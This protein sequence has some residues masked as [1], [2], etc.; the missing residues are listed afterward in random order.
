[1][2]SPNL[3]LS[4]TKEQLSKLPTLTYS[5]RVVEINTVEQAFSAINVLRSNLIVG[6]DTET[7]PSFRKGRT[8]NVSLLQIATDDCCYL[9][10]LNQIGFIPEMKTLFEDESITKV[11][12]SLRDDFKQLHKIGDFEPKSVIELQSFVRDY[13]IADSS[14]QK[15]YGIIFGKRISKSQ[16]LSNWETPIL[17]EAQ[18]LYASLDAWACLKIYTYLKSGKFIPKDNPYIFQ[19]PLVENII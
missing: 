10:R 7:K 3:I 17:T 5:G 4:I 19:P 15:I 11:G 2:Y 18:K 13:N 1:M 12:L 8:N 16:R 6:V 9:F 14:L